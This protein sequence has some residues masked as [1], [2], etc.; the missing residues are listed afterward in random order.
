M[1][2]QNCHHHVNGQQPRSPAGEQPQYQQSSAN[3][4]DQSQHH[5]GRGRSG[6]TE[7]SKE[8]CHSMKAE[9]E[10]LLATMNQKYGSYDH[11]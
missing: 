5:R 3:E 2:E 4:L 10:Q 8:S 11:A 1:N 9:D 6:H 7:G